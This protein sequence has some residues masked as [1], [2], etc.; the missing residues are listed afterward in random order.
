[1]ELKNN[2]RRSGASVP[3]KVSAGIAT[4]MASGAALA[5]GGSGSPGAAIAGELSGGKADVMLVVAAAAVILGA[6]ILW[7]YVK[8]A[9]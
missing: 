7:G 3:A 6:I 4:L 1:M 5:S 2:L 9:R 8:K